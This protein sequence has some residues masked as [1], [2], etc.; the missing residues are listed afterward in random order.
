MVF[1][2]I[3]SLKKGFYEKTP[4]FRGIRQLTKGDCECKVNA[5]YASIECDD[6]LTTLDAFDHAMYAADP[7]MLFGTALEKTLTSYPSGKL[8]ISVLAMLN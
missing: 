7:P 4:C 2:R 6:L 1:I 3:I 5:E 8:M